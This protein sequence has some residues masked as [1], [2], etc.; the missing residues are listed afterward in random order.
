M[1][2]YIFDH[3]MMLLV[4]LMDE[5]KIEIEFKKKMAEKKDKWSIYN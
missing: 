4:V 3:L 1:D 2:V 5:E